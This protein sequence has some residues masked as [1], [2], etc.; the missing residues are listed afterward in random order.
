MG[1]RTMIKRAWRALLVLIAFA[2]CLASGAPASAAGGNGLRIETLSSDPEMV[3]G[4]D[5][6]VAVSVPARVKP[7]SVRVRLNGRNVSSALAPGP[8]GHRL[9]GLITGLDR[10]SNQLTAYARGQRKPA[11]LQLYDAPI[12]GPIFSGPQQTPFFCRTA[13]AGLG[14][15]TD[16]NCSAPTRVSYVYKATNGNFKPL[17][18]PST[19]PADGVQ[20][21]TRD[22]RTVDYIVRIETGVIDRSIYRWSILAP[23]GRLGDGWNERLVYRFLGGCGT[24]YQQGDSS[25]NAVLDDDVLSQGYSMLSGSLNVF[26]TACNDVL[27]AEAASMLKE[28][29]IEQLGR[30]PVWTIGKGGSGGSIQAQLIAQ[31]Y[32]GVLDGLLPSASFPDASSPDYPD[33]RLLSTYFATPNGAALSGAQ[34]TA[35]TGLVDPNGCVALSAGADVVNASEGCDESVVPPALIFD[36]AT[37][38]S[39]IRC[40][41]WDS[42]VNVFGRVPATGYARRTL[43]NAGVQYGLKALQGGAISL[44]EFLDLNEGIGGFDDNGEPRAARSVADPEAL[45]I[46]FGS[47]RINQGLGS[48]RNVPVVDTR[49]Y[50][51]DE[52]NVH[53]YV[54]TYRLRA[55]LDRGGGHGNQVMFRAAGSANVGPMNAAALDLIGRWLDAIAAD[56]SDRS[57]AEKVL[58]N[59]PA[60]AVDACWTNGG[61][62]TD[63]VAAI[64]AQNLCEQTYPPHSLPIDQAGRPL[65]SATLKC[66]LRPL[67]YSDYG[68]PSPAQQARLTAIFPDGVCDWSQPGVGEGPLAGTWQEFG[69]ERKFSS[70]K[71]KLGLRARARRGGRRAEVKL[72]ARLR[73][74]PSTGFQRVVFERRRAIGW[75]KVAT[76]VTRG[77]RCRATV[78]VRRAALGSGRLRLRARFDGAP[79]LKRARSRVV[80]LNLR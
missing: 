17:A 43:D 19:L 22:G 36:P 16:A 37:N 24:G 77:G 35:I 28:H 64:G 2:L 4:E 78:D 31:N 10:G 57:Q 60:D 12:S 73:P 1:E 9:V 54:N 53:Q 20:T 6:L 63:G 74:C 68:S 79:G 32:P 44:G 59:K 26:N 69:P 34:R 72:R 30:Q 65:D 8:N 76:G 40:T 42:M 38:P 80:R 3:S 70:R 51:D 41:V 55:R 29:V 50:V 18:D 15:A 11:H 21:T 5:A 45:A 48:Y 56:D 71:P 67:Q 33:C 52:I 61:Q 14:A 25:Q 58:A 39:G 66:Q 27:S 62:R 49:S 46:A 13:E 7:S 23:G 75:R 47:G